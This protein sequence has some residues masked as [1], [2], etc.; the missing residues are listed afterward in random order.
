MIKYALVVLV[1]IGAFFVGY[2]SVAEAYPWPWPYGRDHHRGYWEDR[3]DTVGK[4][5]IAVGN[6]GS[7][8]CTGAYYYWNGEDNCNAIPNTVDTPQ[9][10]VDFILWNINSNPSVT[11]KA[12]AAF[13]LH[14]MIG[15]ARDW[16]PTLAQQ[17]DFSIR[18]HANA[19]YIL[20][21][22]D[23]YAYGL[24]SYNQRGTNGVGPNDIALYDD[25]MG[26]GHHTIAFRDPNGIAYYIIKR[27]CA[28]PV[29]YA[30]SALPPVNYT[31]TGWTDLSN[32]TNAAR[33][34]NPLAGD[35][36]V[37]RTWLSNQGPTPTHPTPIWYSSHIMSDVGGTT[38]GEYGGPTHSG[39]FGYPD[40]RN[41]IT[42]VVN[43]PPGTPAGTKYCRRTSWDPVSPGVN[44]GRG[45]T[46]CAT[47]AGTYDLIPLVTNNAPGG[48]VQEG[49]TFTFTFTVDNNGAGDSPNTIGCT[50]TGTQP[51]GIAAP[52]TPTCNVVFPWNAP[53][54]ITV[55]TQNIT[56]GN[57]P[58]G[59]RICRTLT[60]NPAVSGGGARA[61]AENCVTVVKT[62][63]VHFLAGDVWAGGGFVQPD[64][65]CTTNAAAKITTTSRTLSSGGGIAGSSVEYA[66][67]ALD[68]MTRFGSAAKVLLSSDAIGA[69]G[70]SLSFANSKLT[71]P[72]E[73]AATAHCIN[74]YAASYETAPALA[75]GTLNLNRAS[76]TRHVAGNL[77]ISGTLPVGS[78]QIYLVDGDVTISDDIDYVN[79]FPTYANLGELPSL[80]VIAK[81]N[82][83]VN[84]AANRLSGIFVAR[85]TFY[86]CYPKPAVVA[87]T[88]VCSSQL[89]VQG[90]VK[91]G[92]VDLYRAFG[93]S[94]ATAAER[95]QPAEQFNFSP[96]VFLRN[97]LN[98]T[99]APTLRTTQARELAPRF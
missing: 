36:I 45:P 51:S 76:D 31:I 73:Y 97:A 1:L 27:R 30:F 44:N 59:S 46:V 9:E 82:I 38:L 62:P 81:G 56:I 13:I 80:V 89:V 60:V 96:E 34:A 5:V 14:T 20:W 84:D 26:T 57:Q 71:E 93:A 98:N 39:P 92:T 50:T 88:G 6:G 86:T 94:G 75:P 40:T 67:F 61:S 49:D 72:G 52:P 69:V 55:A 19:P 68:K 16:I 91:A 17:Q 70:R 47:V 15:S 35:Q 4:Y 64:G 54:P 87:S 90:A 41:P 65:S 95:K 18:V 29:G 83:F 21:D 7:G 33:G 22:T 99:T 2:G 63:Y 79:S 48:T 42:E 78:Q 66:A 28:N 53:S 24:N 11:D 32:N 37:F 85:N 8:I 10:F 23:I 25:N 43:I 12:G 58:S 3:Y 77:T 74:D